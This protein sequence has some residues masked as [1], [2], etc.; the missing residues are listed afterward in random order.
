MDCICIILNCSLETAVL[1]RHLPSYQ[2][3]TV[4]LNWIKRALIK[5]ALKMSMLTL[6]ELRT[7]ISLDFNISHLKFATSHIG[8]T[9]NKWKKE[10]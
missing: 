3:M 7:P 8:N 10:T 6:E 4:Y 9:A 2:Y 5:K 1:Q